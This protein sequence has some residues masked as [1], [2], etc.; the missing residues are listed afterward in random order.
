[1]IVSLD[2]VASNWGALQCTSDTLHRLVRRS[3]I[4]GKSPRYDGG[5]IVSKSIQLGTPV[6]YVSMNYRCVLC[7]IQFLT[8]VCAHPVASVSGKLFAVPRLSGV[9]TDQVRYLQPSDSSLARRS[10]LPASVTLGCK[11]VGHH[12]TCFL[13]DL[14]LASRATCTALDSEVC[15]RL[16]RGSYEGD[17][18]SYPAFPALCLD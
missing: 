16:R 14:T 3:A 12:F 11:T 13:R 8:H 5:A 15:F 17:D 10:S 4:D 1:M 18:V 9:T 6:V 7:S 2:Q